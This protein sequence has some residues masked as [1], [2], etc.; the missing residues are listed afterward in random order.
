[1]LA[2]S[3]HPSQVSPD[4]LEAA[5]RLVFTRISA[6]QLGASAA[7]R[8]S[9]AQPC[10]FL[11]YDTPGQQLCRYP[12]GVADQQFQVAL[13][14]DPDT[15]I[16][17]IA[18]GYNAQLTSTQ[19]QPYERR[20]A[21]PEYLG[22]ESRSHQQTGARGDKTSQQNKAPQAWFRGKFG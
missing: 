6:D 7:I 17:L 14:I 21:T 4:H 10:V 19:A 18:I 3:R 1:M 2:V 5:P 8:G 15:P 22:I 13:A 20:Q 11:E 12:F 16:G 9:D